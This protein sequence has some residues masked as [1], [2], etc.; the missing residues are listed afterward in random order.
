MA[1]TPDDYPNLGR[2]VRGRSAEAEEL[3]ALPPPGAPATDPPT[4]TPAAYSRLYWVNSDAG[5]IQRSNLDGSQVQTIVSG[6]EEPTGIALDVGSGKVY[7]TEWGSVKRSN[8][9]GSQIESLGTAWGS[10]IAL[11]VTEGKTYLAYWTGTIYRTGLGGSPVETLVSEA[12][13]SEAIA[14]D[15]SR[16]KMYWGGWRGEEI[17]RAD[18][19]GSQLETIVT[20]ADRPHDLAVDEAGGKL[21]WASNAGVQR[22]NLDGSQVEALFTENSMGIALDLAGGKIYW[23]EWIADRIRR[24]NL[25][26]SQVQTIVTGLEWPRD[27]AL[28]HE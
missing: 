15:L 26:G 2:S 24:A 3:I 13:A 21:Y 7:W 17:R 9:D 10:D 27:V 19:D 22:A 16:G 12:G 1:R 8:L 25:D 14:L 5:E 4:R 11:D 28:L 20:G 6:L 23:S 18:L